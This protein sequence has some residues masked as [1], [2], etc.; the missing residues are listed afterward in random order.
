MDALKLTS[1]FSPSAG[2]Q[3]GG[4]GALAPTSF[5]EKI[6]YYILPEGSSDEARLFL[7]R[8]LAYGGTSETARLPKWKSWV[9]TWVCAITPAFAS[10]LPTSTFRKIEIGTDTMTQLVRNLDTLQIAVDNEDAET[11]ETVRSELNDSL[12]MTSLPEPSPDIN[13]GLGNG[14]W[15]GKVALCYYA[16]VLFLAGK[17]MEGEDHSQI[18]RARPRALRGKAHLTEELDFLEGGLR[19]SNHAHLSINNAWSEMG[20]LRS[21]VFQEYANYDAEDTDMSK[22]IIW[23]TMHMLRYSNMS[24]AVITYNFL[25][26]YPWANEVP[27]LKS[28]IST[29]VSSVKEASKLDQR[30]FPFVKLIY[31]DK[32]G[33]F[34]RK[35][36]EP[37]IACATSVQSE[38]AA[39]L[40]DFYTNASF[41]PVVDAFNAEKERRENIRELGLHKKEKEL[42]DFFEMESGG[43]GNLDDAGASAQDT[44]MT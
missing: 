28:S 4:K 11:I 22:D 18:T 9:T 17:R 20:Q 33:L 44:Q 35:E 30:L 32:T 3:R 42:E 5:S 12:G 36:M 39:S 37:L 10:R 6:P 2:F 21:I 31:G 25:Q 16:L 7:T 13:L 26:S 23:T 19:M 8:Y 1:A 43:L 34:P 29:Y 15:I 38:T 24:H 40:A 27:A 14:E 41:N